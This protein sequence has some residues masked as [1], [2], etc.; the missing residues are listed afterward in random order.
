[1]TNILFDGSFNYSIIEGHLKKKN[2]SEVS[3]WQHIRHHVLSC[4][5]RTWSIGAPTSQL[6]ILVCLCKVMHPQK[7]WKRSIEHDLFY[8]IMTAEALNIT[9]NLPIKKRPT[10]MIDFKQYSR[11]LR[12]KEVNTIAEMIT[13]LSWS[14]SKNTERKIPKSASEVVCIFIFFAILVTWFFKSI[15][16][17]FERDS[18]EW[19]NKFVFSN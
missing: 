6:A 2:V 12:I 1:M 10:Q 19:K 7:I 14:F 18:Q 11:R 17:F 13:Q 4:R 9:E 15:F 5:F 3:P 16:A 8:N